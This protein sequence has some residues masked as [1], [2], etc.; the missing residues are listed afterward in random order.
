MASKDIGQRLREAREKAGLTQAQAVEKLGIPKAQ[1]LSAYENGKNSPPLEKIGE[2]CVLYGVSTDYII[3]GKKN[4]YRNEKDAVDHAEDLIAACDYLGLS[5]EDYCYGDR[6]YCSSDNYP[7]IILRNDNLNGFNKFS[8]DWRA[9]RNLKETRVLR[10]DFYHDLMRSKAE[11]LRA[12]VNNPPKPEPR[13]EAQDLAS[14]NP[15][16][17]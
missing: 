17:F 11:Q 8:T 16:P 7:A 2:M 14:S 15:L 5:I 4:N 1:T 10:E 9:I 12:E 3:L 13:A 6:Y